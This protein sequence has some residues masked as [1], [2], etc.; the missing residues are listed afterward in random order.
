MKWLFLVPVLLIA[1]CMVLKSDI[2]S[3]G[4][5][6]YMISGQSAGKAYAVEQE[7]TAKAETFCQS[8]QKH[9]AM[10][11]KTDNETYNGWVPHAVSLTFT[12]K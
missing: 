3:V 2:T 11:S 10:I 6:K 7:I 9:L 8:K 5:D 12:C 1:G 4:E